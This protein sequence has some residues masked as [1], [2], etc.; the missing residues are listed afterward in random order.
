[1]QPQAEVLSHPGHSD[2]PKWEPGKADSQD[3]EQD[4]E[5]NMGNV[6]GN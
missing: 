3:P 2:N 1:M 5:A 6:F 4:S